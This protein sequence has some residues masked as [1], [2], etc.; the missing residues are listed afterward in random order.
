MFNAQTYLDLPTHRFTFMNAVMDGLSMRETMA[1]IEGAII[2][3]RRLQ[4]VV[5]NVSKL[6]TMQTDAALRHDVCSSDLINIDGMGVVW[7]ARLCGYH[8][9]ERVSGIDIM[10]NVLRLCA[11]KGFR[12]YFLG[13]KQ[14][15]LQKA[16]GHIQ[17]RY[18]GLSIAG[19]HNG[20]F[21]KDEEAAVMAGIAASK[22]DCLFIAITSPTKERLLAEYKDVIN[23]PF[24]MG[25]G[26]SIDVIAG[27]TQRAPL[28]MQKCGLEWFFRLLQEPRRMFRRYWD[29]NKRYAVLLWKEMQKKK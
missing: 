15:I 4:H 1:I 12:P 18:P 8:V 22:A 29:T 19:Y 9:P 3:R 7:G 27:H 24:L 5:V 14:E 17:A 13:A 6:V 26:G 21:S 25:V 2:A 10:E 20:Y 16:V 11:E 23:V 28:W